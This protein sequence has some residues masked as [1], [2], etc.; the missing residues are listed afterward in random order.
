[1]GSVLASWGLAYSMK[2][3]KTS[4][5]SL[6]LLTAFATFN[7]LEYMGTKS[8]QRNLNAKASEIARNYPEIKYSDVVYTKSEEVGK[9]TLPLY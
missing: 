2:M 7:G 9:R 6:T 8:L 1:M 5:I 4:F 3:K